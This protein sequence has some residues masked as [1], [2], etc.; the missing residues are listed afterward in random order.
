M[1]AVLDVVIDALK[2]TA[3]L[4]PFLF[5]TYVAVS[6]LELFAGD[7]ANATIQRRS[8]ERR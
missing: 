7:R 6:L 8:E 5:L 4:V 3:E 1:Q 2:D